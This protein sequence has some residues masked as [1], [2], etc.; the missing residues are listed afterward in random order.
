MP[1][2]GS[3]RCFRLDEGRRRSA[4]PDGT[5][6]T[7]QIDVKIYAK[8]RMSTAHAADFPMVLRVRHTLTKERQ[9]RGFRAPSFRDVLGS[10][11]SSENTPDL[12]VFRRNDSRGTPALAYKI[13]RFC[14]GTL[15]S[16]YQRR[17]RRSEGAFAARHCG[18]A[19]SHEADIATV[20][21]FGMLG[22]NL[23]LANF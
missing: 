16:R 15:E 11:K 14:L 20:R 7:R 3:T 21:P 5:Q 23:R 8:G 2:T 10:R 9:A 1:P 6:G 17:C 19:L 22:A 12:S 13:P 18:N 4:D